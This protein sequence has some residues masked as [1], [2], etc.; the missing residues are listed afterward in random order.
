[1]TSTFILRDLRLFTGTTTIE[2]GYIQITSGLITSLGPISQCP[3]LPIP[4]FSLP[5]HTL[6]PGL[7]DAHIHA[8]K[9]N[10]LAL[11]QSLAFGITTVCDMANELPNVQKL[12]K[13]TKEADTAD[14][15]TA[16]QAATIENGWPIPVITAHDKSEETLREIASWP[17]LKTR[18]DVVEYLDWNTREMKPDYIKLMHESGTSLGMQL[19]YP[20]VELQ[21]IIV[22]EAKKRGY[23]VV[24]HALSLR[25]ALEVL[26]AGV[27]GTTH[28]ICDQPPTRELV[29]AYKRNGAWCNPTLAAIG[30]LT[31][32]GQELQERFAHDERV[33]SILAE[34]EGQKMC[35]CMAMGMNHS[36][37]ENAYESVRMLREAGVDI[38]CGSDAAGPALGT[39]YGLTMHHELHLFVKKIGMSPEEALKSATS[40][41]ASRFKFEDRGRLAEGL[42]GDLL[43]V[44]GN[45]LEDI[46][47]TLNIRGVWR[48]GKLCSVWRDRFSGGKTG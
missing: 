46:N 35:K 48:D 24:A 23:L 38:I 13:Q 5:H 17:K 12:H 44:E 18:E 6:L 45:P 32:E 47:D 16:G 26:E 28:T 19:E 15:K 27:D 8:D 2:K 4:T 3:D 39:A 37:V 41:T 1:M 7:I 22:E 30:S 11:T 36:K 14:Y 43:L 40:L 33:E 21:K 42:K 20:S 34:A 9:G 31:T 29:E 10:P 25:D